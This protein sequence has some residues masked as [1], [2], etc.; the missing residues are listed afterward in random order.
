MAQRFPRQR[1]GVGV[2]ALLGER[3]DPLRLGLVGG[4]VARG[5][6]EP[7]ALQQHIRE[8]LRVIDPFNL[9][10]RPI[11]G[12]SC[13]LEPT[14]FRM[15]ARE[16]TEQADLHGQPLAAGQG[17]Q[18]L[19]RVFH[20]RAVL[21]DGMAEAGVVEVDVRGHFRR[22]GIAQ[23]PLRL[24]QQAFTEAVVPRPAAPQRFRDQ[25]PRMH[26]GVFRGLPGRGG[27]HARA[28]LAF[29]VR[30]D[31]AGIGFGEME[32]RR[33][34][35]VLGPLR[36]LK[37]CRN[38]VEGG[39]GRLQRED[40]EGVPGKRI[41]V[42]A[43]GG[44]RLGQHARRGRDASNKKSEQESHAGA[45]GAPVSH[46]FPRFVRTPETTPLLHVW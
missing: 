5:A 45:M 16:V 8:Q 4:E 11:Q 18:A 12:V 21:A 23:H 25:A 20:R 28:D 10:L 26:D 34:A 27:R 22:A 31:P 41:D 35:R 7:A 17:R 32:Q 29:P 40:L 15:S 46:G 13:L 39:L 36:R 43:C 6:G 44:F 30:Q 2:V 38:L 19:L 3:Q 14:E 24:R 33:G 1:F 42:D 37:R 9:Q